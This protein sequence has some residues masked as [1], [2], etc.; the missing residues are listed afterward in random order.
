MQRLCLPHRGARRPGRRAGGARRRRPAH[1]PAH[2]AAA[3]AARGGPKQHRQVGR[4]EGRDAPGG[5]A[6][7]LLRLHPADR[8]ARPPLPGRGD[9]VLTV[10][11][12]PGGRDAVAHHR[13][14]RLP[15]ERGGR[16]SS[17]DGAALPF[18]TANR[19]AFARDGRAAVAA[20]RAR[21]GR[22]SRT[23]R[24]RAERRSPTRSACAASARPTPRSAEACPGR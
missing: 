22:R 7:R 24:A 8:L 20:V 23:R 17:A 9:V 15:A 14:V 18:Y 19:S 10:T 13:R 21:R 1:R 3:P 6:D 2:A 16:R 12:R 4:L 11:E 5:R